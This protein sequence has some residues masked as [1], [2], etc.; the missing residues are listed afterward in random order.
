MSL[1]QPTEEGEI[2]EHSV[3][4]LARKYAGK[5]DESEIRPVVKESYVSFADAKV[6]TFVPVF[7]TRYADDRLRALARC[8]DSSPMRHRRCSSCACTTPA[9]R[10]WQPAASPLV[11]RQDRGL[12]GWLATGQGPQ[13]SRS[14]SHAGSR[15]RHRQ[16]IPQALRSGDCAVRRRGHHHGLWRHLP[17]L[18]RQA[19]RRLGARR[20]G[21]TRSRS[22]TTDSRRNQA[23]RGKPDSRPRG[24]RQVTAALSRRLVAESLGT[25]LLIVAVVGS[26]IMATNLT[27][28]VAVQLLANAGARSARSSRSSSCSA[29]SRVPTSTPWSLP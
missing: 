18:P 1:I 15:H 17:D 16:R 25:G 4:Q 10:R 20:P 6:R 14:C 12:L 23:S 27:D 3:S 26:G 5:F 8:A 7:T 19:L 22:R 29:R 13:R 2:I 9:V 11:A 24:R 21:R 28:D